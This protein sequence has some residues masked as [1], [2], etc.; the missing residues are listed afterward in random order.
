MPTASA[1]ALAAAATADDP[2]P[3]T[4]AAAGL[5][6]VRPGVD[7][8]Y[9]RR[10]AG[11]GFAY[12][13]G[14]RPLRDREALARIRALAIPPA[15][16][17]V[18]IARDP[19]GHVQATGRDARGRLQYRYHPIWRAVRDAAKFDKLTAFCGAMPA[20]R[21]R[22][23]RDL[24][25]RCLCRDCVTATAVAL[26]ERGHLRVGNDEYTRENGSYG[27]TTLERRH[28]R[29]R[30][31]TVHLTYRGKSGIRRDVEIED[32]AVVR[33]LRRIHALPGRRLFQW[34]EAGRRVAITSADVNRYVRDAMGEA[35]SAKDFRTWA[36]TLH[37]AVLLAAA[38]PPASAASGKRTVAAAIAEVAA[39][40]GHT[41]AVCRKSYVDPRVVEAYRSGALRDH[42]PA[43]VRG[44]AALASA[45]GRLA[46]ERA[47]RRFLGAVEEPPVEV[48][49]LAARRKAIRP[50]RS[51]AV[52]APIPEAAQAA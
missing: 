43:A 30:G 4:A 1:S 17:A 15:W 22:L 28:V 3:A 48:V 25:C 52:A 16:T 10:R 47:L 50:R 12:R 45:T 21:R 18:W 35:F 8:G 6:Y 39:D 38:E 31:S 14:D 51:P 27:A 42:F 19:L 37:C 7:P 5:H 49:S 46:A 36:A 13:D 33:A 11:R 32:L 9:Q 20:L 24:G 44:A 40:L 34:R 29:L 41:A 2:G 23:A 26:I